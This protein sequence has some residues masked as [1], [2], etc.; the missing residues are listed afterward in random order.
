MKP[1]TNHRAELP[2]DIARGS[3]SGQSLEKLKR[4]AA[5]SPL[6]TK[7]EGCFSEWTVYRELLSVV[8][9]YAAAADKKLR[10]K[11]CFPP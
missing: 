3:P 7:K 4:I 2:T 5:E 9:G 10:Y 6:S 11:N 8:S 1:N